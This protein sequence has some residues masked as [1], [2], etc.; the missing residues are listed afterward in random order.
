MTTIDAVGQ[1]FDPNLHEALG[2]EAERG[3]ARRQRDPHAAQG[4]QAARPVVAAG[5]RVCGQ[6]EREVKSRASSNLKTR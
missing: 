3:R 4:L 1:K 5:E 6:G 2:E